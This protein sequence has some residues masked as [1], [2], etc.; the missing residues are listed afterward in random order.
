MLKLKFLFHLKNKYCI[1]LVLALFPFPSYSFDIS[2]NNLPYFHAISD[3]NLNKVKI[4]ENLI[5]SA[6]YGSN[7][8][9]IQ[10]ALTLA[11]LVFKDSGDYRIVSEVCSSLL[12]DG[13]TESALLESLLESYYLMEDY[14]S[15]VSA[16]SKYAASQTSSGTVI[17][18]SQE[19]EYYSFLAELYED[20]NSVADDF[21]ELLVRNPASEFIVDAYR[22]IQEFEVGLPFSTVLL[23]EFKIQLFNRKY[24]PA[25]RTMIQLL[26]LQKETIIDTL[27]NGFIVDNVILTPVIF[28]EMY[29]VANISGKGFEFLTFIE[30]FLIFPSLAGYEPGEVY[31]YEFIAGLYETAGYLK[32]RKGNFAD[33][34]DLFIQGLP[35]VTGRKHEKMLWYWYNSLLHYSPEKA[36]GQIGLLVDRWTDPDYFSDVLT[37]LATFFVQQGQWTVIRELLDVYRSQ[38]R[39]NLYQNMLILQPV[40]GW[41]LI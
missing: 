4:K 36:A 37:E 8:I 14:R 2:G 21:R 25:S 34:S 10:A 12:D 33:A 5:H 16:V 3:S 13:F 17:E 26:N 40:R 9:R 6:L 27:D 38:V 35:F 18:S 15:L 22:H 31:T 39:M 20:N 7:A 24:V 41:N 11:E 29:R 28:N 1:V 32:R 19:I 23:V 30:E